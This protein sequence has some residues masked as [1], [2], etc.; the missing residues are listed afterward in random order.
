M[1][2]MILELIEIFIKQQELQKVRRSTRKVMALDVGSTDLHVTYKQVD[3][4]LE[5]EMHVKE[6]AKKGV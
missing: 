6:A 1:T 5:T 3:V 4:G 2:D